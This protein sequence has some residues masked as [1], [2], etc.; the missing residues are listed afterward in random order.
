M[1]DKNSMITSIDEEN[2]F[3]KIQDSSWKKT[4]NKQG[5]EV[6]HLNIK[7]PHMDKP[8]ADIWLSKSWKYFPLNPFFKIFIYFISEMRS[9]YVA[10]AD[11]K[12]LDSSDPL[13]SASQSA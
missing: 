6:I 9:H 11:L 13:T 3:D 12:L 2:A 4:V 7:M 5:I 8:K 1:K 10:Q